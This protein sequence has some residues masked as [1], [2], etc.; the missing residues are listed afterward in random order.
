MKTKPFAVGCRVCGRTDQRLRRGLC[1]T[2]YQAWLELAKEMTPEDRAEY[3]QR[4]IA[5][6]WLAEKASAKP[7]SEGTPFGEIAKE[8]RNGYKHD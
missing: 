8:V 2:H 3:E 1:Q 4:C 7:K 5:S 6:G